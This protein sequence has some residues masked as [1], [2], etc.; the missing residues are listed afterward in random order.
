MSLTFQP[1][2]VSQKTQTFYDLK[3]GLNGNTGTFTQKASQTSPSDRPSIAPGELRRV[4]N[5][6]TTATQLA[7]GLL[8]S[9][10]GLQRSV[11]NALTDKDTT[12]ER[13]HVVETYWKLQAGISTSVAPRPFQANPDPSTNPAAYRASQ[14]TAW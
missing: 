1:D 12:Q 6:S 7:I 8:G 4:A 10:P 13:L 5:G 11:V 9:Q 14:N 3:N 2:T